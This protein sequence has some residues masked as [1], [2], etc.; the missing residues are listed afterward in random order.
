MAFSNRPLRNCGEARARA[1]LSPSTLPPKEGQKLSSAA[2]AATAEAAS[3]TA[4]A[5][6]LLSRL[7][8]SLEVRAGRAGRVLPGRQLSEGRPANSSPPN[9][10]VGT[11]RW[12]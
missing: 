4:A 2:P 10:R 9:W 1:D 12:N 5:A 11:A 6:S 8:G 7:I 3:T